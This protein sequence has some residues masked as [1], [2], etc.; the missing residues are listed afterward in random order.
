MSAF[1]G[2]M[3]TAKFSAY[4]RSRR[5]SLEP[6]ATGTELSTE[7]HVNCVSKENL[8]GPFCPSPPDLFEPPPL[9]GVFVL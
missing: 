9:E 1:E 8:P 5:T 2:D 4:P 6:L 7:T 3:D